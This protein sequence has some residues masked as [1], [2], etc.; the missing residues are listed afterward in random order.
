[1]DTINET[2]VRFR[3]KA[4]MDLTHEETRAALIQALNEVARLENRK[5]AIVEWALSPE[6]NSASGARI[7]P[8]PD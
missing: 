4:I 3:G 5:P 7:M 6:R 2:N 1:M 8:R